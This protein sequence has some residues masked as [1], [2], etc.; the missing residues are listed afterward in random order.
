MPSI[1]ITVCFSTKKTG[2]RLS[3]QNT[4]GSA[5]G[6]THRSLSGQSLEQEIDHPRYFDDEN[7]T[8]ANDMTEAEIYDEQ[9]FVKRYQLHDPPVVKTLVHSE[10]RNND[11]VDGHVVAASTLP[12]Q[13]LSQSQSMSSLQPPSLGPIREEEDNDQPE[14]RHEDTLKRSAVTDLDKEMSR[15]GQMDSQPAQER[16]IHTSSRDLTIQPKEQDSVSSPLY[17][18]MIKNE[19]DRR[20]QD[21][22]QQVEQNLSERVQ[23]LEIK[24]GAAVSTVQ[25]EDL[26]GSYHSR[27]S[28][29]LRKEMLSNVSQRVGDL[30]SRVNQMET[31]V[32]YKLVDIESKVRGHDYA[33]G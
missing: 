8:V 21:A 19:L 27:G 11:F 1:R 31:M 17:D 20:I 26:E 9:V 15:T 28:Q 2:A 24:T 18:D 30:D 14:H 22:V 12:A 16:N 3:F 5:A 33:F 10:Q 7:V 25:N 13:S 23:R 29:A 32:S 4:K 6:K